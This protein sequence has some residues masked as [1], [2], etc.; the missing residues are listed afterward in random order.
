MIQHV[1]NAVKSTQGMKQNHCFKTITEDL[2]QK[3]NIT[4]MYPAKAKCYFSTINVYL[5]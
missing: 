1:T 2:M 5:W 4:M 3:I